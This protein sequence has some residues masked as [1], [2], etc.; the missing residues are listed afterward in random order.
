MKITTNGYGYQIRDRINGVM[1]TKTYIGFSEHQ[2]VVAY[3]KE[4]LPGVMVYP[5]C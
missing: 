1:H 4:F 5:G 2:A 3:Y